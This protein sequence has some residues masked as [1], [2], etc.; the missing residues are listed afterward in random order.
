MRHAQHMVTPVLLNA[1]A[2]ASRDDGGGGGNWESVAVSAAAEPGKAARS[3]TLP[4]R[5]AHSGWF[6]VRESEEAKMVEVAPLPAGEANER[7]D[8][9]GSVFVDGKAGPDGAQGAEIRLCAVDDA[10]FCMYGSNARQSDMR[11]DEKNLDVDPGERGGLWGGPPPPWRRVDT[12]APLGSA[13]NPRPFRYADLD[14]Y[15]NE[16]M[17]VSLAKLK[18]QV[19]VWGM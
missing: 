15:V 6:Y 16:T 12:R 1:A 7:G 14:E 18:E 3:R 19:A 5:L 10:T 11:P 4:K 2:V 8:R 13:A 9:W 17:P